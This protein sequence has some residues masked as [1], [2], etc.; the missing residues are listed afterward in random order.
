MAFAA[1]EESWTVAQGAWGVKRLESGCGLPRS[2]T[3]PALLRPVRKLSQPQQSADVIQSAQQRPGAPPGLKGSSLERLRARL[4]G[5]ADLLGILVCLGL[6]DAG[7][8]LS[9]AQRP[10]GNPLVG[11]NPLPDAAPYQIALHRH[12]VLHRAGASKT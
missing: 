5:A 2:T 9:H 11:L 12:K 8:L 6:N 1:G 4:G 10:L 3:L 7:R